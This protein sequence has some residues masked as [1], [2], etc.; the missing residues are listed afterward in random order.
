MSGVMAADMSGR[1][2][3]MVVGLGRSRR[4]F[5]TELRR[6]MARREA[7]LK[8]MAARRTRREVKRRMR[9]PGLLLLEASVVGR[10]ELRGM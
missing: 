2:G 7:T 9:E 1:A 6:G 3:R 5:R 4:W 10:R 8:V